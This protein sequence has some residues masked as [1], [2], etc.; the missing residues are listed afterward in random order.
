[1]LSVLSNASALRRE[2]AFNDH[3]KGFRS[4][5]LILPQKPHELVLAQK[6]IIALKEHQPDMRIDVVAETRSKD[7]ITSNPYIDGGFFY[8]AGTFLYNH[9]LF[10][11]LTG[12]IQA[13]A[14]DA[15]IV[16]NRDEHPLNYYLAAASK[17]PLRMGFNNPRAFPFIN[18]AVQPKA[19]LIYEGDLYE[20]L[21]RTIGVRFPRSRVRWNIP[22]STEKDMEGILVEMGYRTGGLLIGIDLS[23]SVTQKSMPDSLAEDLVRS[24]SSIAGAEVVVMRTKIKKDAPGASFAGKRIVL[25]EEERIAHAAA[26]IYSCSLVVSLNTMTYQLAVLLNRPVIGLFE[27]GEKEQWACL[28]KGRFEYIA[29][30]KLKDTTGA[31]VLERAKALITPG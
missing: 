31:E 11:E 30:N 8:T 10:K 9:P 6:S 3:I 16:L 12:S 27:N 17:A 2:T 15:C 4:V 29:G 14:Y 7:L 5:L 21:L 26:L 23:P 24:L 28:Q 25:L 20:S 13:K 1:M 19:C 18:L 22:K